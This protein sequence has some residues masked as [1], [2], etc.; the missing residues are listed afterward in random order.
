MADLPSEASS[1]LS[2]CWASTFHAHILRLTCGLLQNSS[3]AA[4]SFQVS[5]CTT[6][7]TLCTKASAM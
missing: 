4:T 1:I 2:C 7:R 5:A 6:T 3:R